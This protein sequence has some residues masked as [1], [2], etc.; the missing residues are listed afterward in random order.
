MINIRRMGLIVAIISAV[1]YHQPASAAPVDGS[2]KIRDLVLDIFACQQSVCGRIAWTK[3]PQ[4]R[5]SECGQTI[6]WGLSP[7][8]PNDW[9]GG[10][11][12]DPTDGNTYRLSAS[13]E[14]DGTLHAR[15]YRGVPLF[16]KT[17]VLTRVAARSLDGW[18]A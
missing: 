6:V 1:A 5:Q 4:R 15:I 7:D 17:E 12:Y 3:D 11:I 18:C 9:K 14:P 2:W 13:L 16:G 8:G 10:S